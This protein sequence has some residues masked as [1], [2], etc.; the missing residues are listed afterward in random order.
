MDLRIFYGGIKIIPSTVNL[1]KK[2]KT[3]TKNKNLVTEKVLKG[4][5]CCFAKWTC[6]QAAF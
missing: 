2:R 1:V 3:K 5:I 6:C 4:S